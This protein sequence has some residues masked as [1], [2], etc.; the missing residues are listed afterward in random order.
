[1]KMHERA[2]PQPSRSLA[3][4]EREN[5]ELQLKL[6]KAQEI[7]RALQSEAVGLSELKVV[8]ESLRNSEVRLETEL[9]DTKLLQELSAH[10][11]HEESVDTLYAKITDAALVIMQSDFASMQ[12]YYPERGTAGE[13]R[14][15]A[16]CGLTQEAKDFWEWVGVE[17]GTTCA[18][19]LRTGK[20]F[21]TS[22]MYNCEFVVNTPDHEMF[23]LA[24]VCA[25]QST[26]LYSR[27]GKLLGMIS[28]HWKK[29]HKPSD[30][31]LRLLDILARQ[32][33]DLIERKAAE[34]ALQQS[35]IA[36]TEA[37][38]RKDEFLATLAHELRNPLAPI[39]NALHIMRIAPAGSKAPELLSMMDRQVTHL[40]RLIDDLLDVSRVS[41]G[42]I[43][44][45]L[46]K[47]TLQ[48]AVLAATEASLP[49][50][51]SNK[52]ILVFDLPKEPLWLFADLTRVAQVVSNLLNNAAK[53]TPDGGQIT[54]SA[55][56]DGAHAVLSVSDTGVG[57]PADM[58][59]KVF[60]LF[61]QVDRNLERSHG[62][63]G[64]GL[65]LV[66]QLLEM[67]GGQIE[68][69]SLGV[70]HGS[71]F[72]VRL[73]L[74]H[75][76]E[77]NLQGTGSS[78]HVEP[79]DQVALRVLVVDDNIP[80]AETTALMLELIGHEPKVA[81]DGIEALTATKT[82]HPDVILLDIGLPG[83]NGYDLCRE[84][85]KDPRFKDTLMIAQTGWGQ[86]RDRQLARDAGFD[87]HL[88]KPLNF[89][90]LSQLLAGYH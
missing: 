49:L 19:A 17:S 42:K 51:E 39:R 47:I 68:A 85:R 77:D 5:H 32:G 16:S 79:K 28:T 90:E 83:M 6:Q 55:H 61:T 1:M 44:L 57:I 62:G 29:H 60:D 59:P 82:F 15:L 27:N 67:H 14:L 10:L 78:D 3:E 33:A 54:V 81:H 71:I 88:V 74:A 41:Q 72:T 18:V 13:L 45:R 87:H 52:H 24:G 58:L 86:E 76:V 12:M 9:A 64:I 37:D 66:K 65:A 46:D 4:L 75:I 20:R 48:N 34:D 69:K 22:D 31:D 25:A 23:F 53:Y 36:L 56:R 35:K 43:D 26:P 80:S 7:I 8:E 2:I 21:I 50:I 38:R 89:E 30:R 63:L 73:P 40:V 84:L 70:G 11:I